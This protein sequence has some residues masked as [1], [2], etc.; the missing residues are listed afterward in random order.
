MLPWKCNGGFP[1]HCCPA[2]KYFVLLVTTIIFQY[3]E[4]LCVSFLALVIWRANRFFS[5][6]YCIVISGISD[7]HIYPRCSINC[8]I[9]LKELLN[10]ECV[11]W[12]SLQL[13]SEIFL[14]LN[15]SQQDIFIK[16][17]R[18]SCKEP[19]IRL[20][21]KLNL[22]DSSSKKT[23]IRFHEN[24]FI[25]TLRYSMRTDRHDETNSRFSK[26]YERS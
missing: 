5:A 3:C 13:L 1:S 16:V 7:Y 2:T 18:S 10:A 15:R 22:S 4:F 8:T 9:L 23:H 12:F 19:G 24:P 14:L 21:W 25:E 6:P 26:F 17:C 11:F 20:Y